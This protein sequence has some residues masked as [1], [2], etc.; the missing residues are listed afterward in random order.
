MRETEKSSHVLSTS[1]RPRIFFKNPSVDFDLYFVNKQG[2]AKYTEKGKVPWEFIRDTLGISGDQLNDGGINHDNITV[3]FV[4]NRAAEKEIMTP[5]TMAHRIGHV[6]A[7]TYGWEQYSDWLD[8]EFAKIFECYGLK[9]PVK[10][11]EDNKTV[12]A[13]RK[14]FNAIG[15]MR[16]DRQNLIKR[17]YEFTIELFTQYLN[18]GK[19]KFNPLPEEIVIGNAGWGRPLTAK[20]KDVQEVNDILES[21]ENTIGYYVDDAL[22]SN[23]GDIFVM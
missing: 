23:I 11:K 10:Y 12:M 17:P 8:K 1:K 5:W 7:R 18:S 14:I 4:G 3:F 15:T 20:T 6:M 21:I 9:T 19:V 22:S 16:S 2:V 13:Q